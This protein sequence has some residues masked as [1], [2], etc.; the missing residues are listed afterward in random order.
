METEGGGGWKEVRD[1]GRVI[2]GRRRRVYRLPSQQVSSPV[3]PPLP[4]PL[5]SSTPS[6]QDTSFSPYTRNP[7]ITSSVCCTKATCHFPTTST[8]TPIAAPCCVSGGCGW[9]RMG[10]E[11]R[12]RKSL[13]FFFFGVAH[14]PPINKLYRVC[15]EE[16]VCAQTQCKFIWI[17]QGNVGCV[18]SWF[19]G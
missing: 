14:P 2:A 11:V 19:W 4:P 9:G 7:S 18:V 15:M 12:S 5:Y 8:S 17:Q 13:F 16:V 1:W 10:L 6:D 3:L